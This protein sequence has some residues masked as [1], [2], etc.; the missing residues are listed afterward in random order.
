M[1]SA[2]YAHGFIAV[3]ELAKAN[4]KTAKAK[5][6]AEKLPCAAMTRSVFKLL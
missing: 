3:I 6:N 2:Y 1:C 4:T 5:A